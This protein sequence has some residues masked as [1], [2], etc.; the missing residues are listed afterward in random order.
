MTSSHQARR[1]LWA[2]ATVLA[3]A[4]FTS[5]CGGGSDTSSGG[6]GESGEPQVG[7]VLKVGVASAVTTLD[8]A[9]GSANAMALSGY[10]IY[11][12]LMKVDKLG[13]TP[14]PQIA[15]SLESNADF[16]QWTMKLPT[17]LKFSDDTPFNAAAVKFNMDRHIDPSTASTAASLLSS[18]ESVEAPDDTTV[19]FNLKYPFA[20]LPYVLSY[21]GSGTAG[22]I[23][24]PTALQTYGDDYTA[25]A[26][27][28][29]PYKVKS[30]SAGSDIVLE[31]NP[32]YWN[33]AEQEPYLDEIDIKTIEDEQARYSALQSGDIDYAP[34]INP[35]IMTQAESNSQIQVVHGVG[36]DQDSIA[37][38]MTHAPFDDIRVRQAISYALNR[39]EI[40]DL[41]KEG[42]AEPAVNLFPATDPYANDNSDPE[43]DLDKAKALVAEYEADTGKKVEFT[44]MCRPTVNTTEVVERQLAAAGMTVKIDVQEST[45]AVANFIGGKYDAACWTMAGFLTPDLLP[46][47]FFYSTGDLNSTGFNDPE[48]DSL[49]DQARQTADPAKQKELWV[50]ADKILTEELPWVWVTS[51]PIAF[52]ARSNVHSVDLDEPSRL[53]YSVPTVNNVWLSE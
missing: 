10:A 41:T 30:W 11:D 51:Q 40:V 38:N 33:T 31:R 43:F 12:T 17:G 15:E 29:G 32:N 42:L 47:R 23:A 36:S 44:Y 50:A 34:S 18:V 39:E 7:G 45:T 5:A 27:G 35:T 16:T 49:A 26:A 4:A 28:L 52:L 9:K 20:N 3:L 24:S 22:Y 48:F 19:I 6:S 14:Q 25:H 46:Y 13:D 37:L 1:R 2:V 21:D 8:P 53:R